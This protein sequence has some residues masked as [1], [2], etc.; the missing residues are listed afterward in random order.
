MKVTSKKKLKK[1]REES[2]KVKYETWKKKHEQRNEEMS[3]VVSDSDSDER[4]REKRVR[5]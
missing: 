2:R 3:V 1:M 5:I 4:K